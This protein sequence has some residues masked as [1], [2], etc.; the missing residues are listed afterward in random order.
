[1]IEP[2]T[3][4]GPDELPRDEHVCGHSVDYGRVSEIGS[5]VIR[6]GRCFAPVEMDV[7]A[8]GRCSCQRANAYDTECLLT[9]RC[10]EGRRA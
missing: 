5:G 10:A 7:R 6:C 3:I 4:P 8:T 1:V 2:P 9:G